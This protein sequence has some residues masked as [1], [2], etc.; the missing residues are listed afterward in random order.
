[1]VGLTDKS[2]GIQNK[3]S[4]APED[5]DDVIRYLTAWSNRVVGNRYQLAVQQGI[6]LLKT[7]SLPEPDIFWVDASHRRGRPTPVN[8]PLIIEVTVSSQEHDLIVKQ[9][10]YAMEGIAEYWV[11]LPQS[12]TIIVHRQPIGERYANVETFGI[13]QA[14]SPVCIPEATLDLEWL[15]R[16]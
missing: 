15:F 12:A 9:R 16:G 5:Q 2:L 1:V 4:P 10:L 13:G 6:R 3:R 14:I 11:V 7:E 8:V